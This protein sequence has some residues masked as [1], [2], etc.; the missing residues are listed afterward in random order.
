MQSFNVRVGSLVIGQGLKDLTK[1]GVNDEV[2][3]G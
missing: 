1:V 2:Q 3:T